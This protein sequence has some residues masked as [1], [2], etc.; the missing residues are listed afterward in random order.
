MRLPKYS[1]LPQEDSLLPVATGNDMK[2]QNM[3]RSGS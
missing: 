3:I 1:A 2:L